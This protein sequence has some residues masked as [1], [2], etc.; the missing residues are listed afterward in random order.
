MPQIVRAYRGACACAGRRLLIASPAA[1]EIPIR[2][3][4]ATRL[5]TLASLPASR[6]AAAA[7]SLVLEPRWQRAATGAGFALTLGAGK[8]LYDATGPGNASLKDFTW[9][10]A[11]AALGTALALLIDVIVSPRP[12]P[13]RD[14]ATATR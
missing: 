13:T 7:S 14:A 5:C 12:A 6:P 4:V 10:V 2:G 1:A 3:G 8:E 11:G 9:D